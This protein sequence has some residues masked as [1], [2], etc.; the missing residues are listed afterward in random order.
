MAKAS[1]KTSPAKRKELP[2]SPTGIRGLD[3]I[4]FSGLPKGRPPLV[5]GLAGSRP[6]S[7]GGCSGFPR[8]DPGGEERG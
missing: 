4:T 1:G 6:G 2:K 5:C 7:G 8:S 3:E